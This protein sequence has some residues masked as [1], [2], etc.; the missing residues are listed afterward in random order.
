[1]QAIP[2]N[3]HFQGTVE[4]S[5][6]INFFFGPI[7][8]L[9]GQAFLYAAIQS[10]CVQNMVVTAQ[11]F[12]NLLV[13]LFKRTCGLAWPT[14]TRSFTWYCVTEPATS[15][16]SPF[17]DVAMVFTFGL[18]L[19]LILCIPLS[20]MNLDDNI[21][22]QMGAFCLT[23]VILS[24]WLSSSVLSGLKGE[25]VPVFAVKSGFQSS[26]GTVM[27]NMACTIFVPSWINL[28]RRNV[29]AQAT[30]WTAMLIAVTLY[31][32]VGTITALAYPIPSSG[33]I[34][35]TLTQLGIPRVLTTST[36]YAFAFVMLLPSIPVSFIVAENNLTQNKCLRFRRVYNEKR[37]LS[38][39]QKQLLKTIHSASNT[40]ATFIDTSTPHKG[41]RRRTT[42]RKR[43]R[44]PSTLPR[45]N[46]PEEPNHDA[47][48]TKAYPRKPSRPPAPAN[49]YRL[50]EEEQ[51]N[52]GIRVSEVTLAEGGGSKEVW[53]SEGEE[54]QEEE[55]EETLESWIYEEDVPDPDAEDG[56]GGWGATGIERNIEG[57]INRVGTLSRSV[58][59]RITVRGDVGDAT[60]PM[61]LV[62]PVTSV[63][64]NPTAASSRRSP[65]PNPSPVIDTETA[66]EPTEKHD[67]TVLSPTRNQSASTPNPLDHLTPTPETTRTTL[68][69]TSSVSFAVATTHTT[70]PPQL[71]PSETLLRPPGS[72][73]ST[74]P[75][76]HHSGSAAD[77]DDSE[78][79]VV[80]PPLAGHGGV[81]GRRTTLPTHPD[82]IAPTFRS[83][84][85]TPL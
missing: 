8:H 7:A 20:L 21:G 37:V 53:F 38:D 60:T 1:M 72:P 69:R 80:P 48:P 51:Q 78:L 59:R 13:V 41:L 71:N 57:A 46:L 54:E 22:L 68:H 30:V 70:T 23:V 66:I 2:G 63:R 55:R 58:L 18:L 43:L 11:S 74:L 10:Q 29:N 36:C 73:L 75:R 61:P 31:L 42:T 27:Q 32:S 25:L 81:A 82:F 83:V 4:F 45:S 62:S 34:I 19:V 15:S 79:D 77:D 35:P 9:V 16:G 67:M 76:S 64:R 50:A 6:L 17:H 84:P 56:E 44:R 24:Q 40:I 52:D 49:E 3:R 47:S 65:S 26:L 85:S 14:S 28:K 5:T 39:K 12:D 33:N